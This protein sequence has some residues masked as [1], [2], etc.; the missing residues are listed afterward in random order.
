MA[1]VR[2]PHL[3]SISSEWPI[4]D[5]LPPPGFPGSEFSTEN[6]LFLVRCIQYRQT[7]RD[8]SEDDDSSL[9]KCEAE[10]IFDTFISPNAPFAI[11]ISARVRDELVSLFRHHGTAEDVETSQVHYMCNVFDAAHIEI[12]DLLPRDSLPRFLQKNPEHRRAWDDF[13]AELQRFES[14]NSSEQ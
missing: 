5:V 12:R 10:S 2:Q 11:N 9:T 1:N 7:Y 6:Q 3:T 8:R 4:A 13:Q 14:S